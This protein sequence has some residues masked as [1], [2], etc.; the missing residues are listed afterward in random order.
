MGVWLGLFCEYFTDSVFH[1]VDYWGPL[2]PCTVMGPHPSNV[3]RF[4]YVILSM[5]M[6]LFLWELFRLFSLHNVL[7][8]V[9]PFGRGTTVLVAR[10]YVLGDPTSVSIR[11]A[12]CLVG[13][14]R[15][16]RRFGL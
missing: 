4:I 9:A 12:K 10:W 7:G 2:Y 5:Y 3:A 1:I 16:W 15:I 11:H 14:P 8:R 13:V 6:E